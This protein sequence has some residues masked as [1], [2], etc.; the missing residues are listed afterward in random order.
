MTI[1]AIR[2]SVS[3]AYRISNFSSQ[4]LM[5]GWVAQRNSIEH[6]EWRMIFSFRNNAALN[7]LYKLTNLVDKYERIPWG[8]VMHIYASINRAIISSE[9]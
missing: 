7:M 5:Q 8:P 2:D 3:D 6:C 4:D 1:R 9:K